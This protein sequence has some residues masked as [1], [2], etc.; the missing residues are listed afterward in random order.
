MST[1]ITDN[2]NIPDNQW[3]TASVWGYDSKAQFESGSNANLT[4]YSGYSSHNEYFT[5]PAI[6][7]KR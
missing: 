7:R 5:L 6:V 1:P 4:V 3:I 2:L